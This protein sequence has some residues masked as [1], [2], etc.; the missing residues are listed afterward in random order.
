MSLFLEDPKDVPYPKF[1]INLSYG[2]SFYI[3]NSS[4]QNQR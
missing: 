1:D 4:Q 3:A 2:N